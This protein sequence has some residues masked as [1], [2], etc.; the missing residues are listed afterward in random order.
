MILRSLSSDRPSGKKLW[1]PAAKLESV[2]GSF[3]PGRD[4]RREQPGRP[5]THSAAAPVVLTYIVAQYAAEAF[6]A[7]DRSLAGLPDPRGSA[8]TLSR[9]W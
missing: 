4:V 6:V 1:H 9:P 7:S 8:M 2:D 5:T 3:V